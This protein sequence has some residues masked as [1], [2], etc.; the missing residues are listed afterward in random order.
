[1]IRRSSFKSIRRP[2]A[3]C[4]KTHSDRSPAPIMSA[5]LGVAGGVIPTIRCSSPLVTAAAAHAV[6]RRPNMLRA[7]RSTG[8]CCEM[9][10]AVAAVC[11]IVLLVGCGA[12]RQPPPSRHQPQPVA[13]L[14]SSLDANE[15]PEPCGDAGQQPCAGSVCNSSGSAP[16]LS[17]IENEVIRV[18]AYTCGAYAGQPCCF[19]DTGGACVDGLACNGAT[20]G[21]IE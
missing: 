13:K 21:F 19:T 16:G 1:T 2:S 10:K 5:C 3:D 4:W 7:K 9:G 8:I 18:C 6:A 11:G 15:D 17:A 20:C 12:S 14:A